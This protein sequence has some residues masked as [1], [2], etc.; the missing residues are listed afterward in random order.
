LD[1]AID[2]VITALLLLCGLVLSAAGAIDGFLQNV[3]Q[4][5]GVDS[6]RQPLILIVVALLIVI[7]LLRA[8]GGVFSGLILILLILM[9]LRWAVPGL[10]MPPPSSVPGWQPSGAVNM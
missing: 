8:L 6:A 7:A 10:H 2:L 9:L 4:H 5:A 1:H 3:M